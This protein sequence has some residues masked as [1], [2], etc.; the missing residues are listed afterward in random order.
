MRQ[1]VLV[2]AVR[3]PVGKKGGVFRNTVRQELV[4]PVV[5]EALRRANIEGK[6]VYDVIWGAHAEGRTPADLPGSPPVSPSP[7]L[8]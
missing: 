5:Q 7:Q 6:D 2:S 3:T 4:T 1:A 8:R